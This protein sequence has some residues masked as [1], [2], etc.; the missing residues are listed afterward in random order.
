MCPKLPADSLIEGEFFFDAESLHLVRADFSPS[1][2]VKKLMFRLKRLD[3]TLVQGPTP[4]GYWL[5]RE[6]R[7]DGKGKAGLLF[8][9]SFGGRERYT[10]PVV[11][12]GLDETI[13]EETSDE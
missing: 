8:G 3:M 11:N 2:L 7:I 12:S 6:F 9:V 13:F 1:K 10:N 5:P 4:E